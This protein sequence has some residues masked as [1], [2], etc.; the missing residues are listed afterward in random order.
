MRSSIGELPT[1]GKIAIKENVAALQKMR[2]RARTQRQSETSDG[3]K[4]EARSSRADDDRRN[5]EMQ[6]IYAVRFDEGGDGPC[7]ALDEDA[8]QSSCEK[9]I[10][11]GGRRNHSPRRA[12]AQEFGAP[13]RR[14]NVRR[15][16]EEAS[17]AVINQPFPCAV[18]TTAGIDRRPRRAFPGD[19]AH[20]ELRIVSDDRARA[21]HHCVDMR[22]QAMQVIERCGAADVARLAADRGDAPVE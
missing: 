3:R 12:E 1:A 11:D 9:R 19:A 16:N 6:S 17:R 5:E 22:P 10:D 4:V 13:E 20:G 7:A 8:A 14:R 18:E 21:Y 2:L 15:T